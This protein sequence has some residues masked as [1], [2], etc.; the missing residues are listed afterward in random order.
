MPKK[1]ILIIDDAEDFTF[2]VK[3]NLEK[4][5]KYEVR[6]ECKGSHGFIAA[7]KFK[8]DLILLD[9]SM[10]D[11]DGG[12]VYSQLEKGAD[13]KNIPIVFLTALAADNGVGVPINTISGRPVIAK[14]ADMD[15]II[16]CIENNI[17]E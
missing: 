9:I 2:L 14:P 12:L 13:T 16:I 7:R 4:T 11:L 8:P 1:K 5:G 6:T 17:I 15:Q 10:P 3:K